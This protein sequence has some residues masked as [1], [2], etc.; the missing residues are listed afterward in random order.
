[1]YSHSVLTIHNHLLLHI[2]KTLKQM[3]SKQACTSWCIHKCAHTPTDNTHTHSHDLHCSC[4]SCRQTTAVAINVS[5]HSVSVSLSQFFFKGTLPEGKCGRGLVEASVFRHRQYF[6]HLSCLNASVLARLNHM[7]GVL[8]WINNGHFG[9]L[10]GTWWP[11]ADGSL[12]SS[13]GTALPWHRQV[14]QHT[15]PCHRP[16]P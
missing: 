4:S 13:M 7:C 3:C 8:S 2:Y 9:S 1:M 12:M 11:R 14:S 15:G 5:Q 16:S 10:A 6:P